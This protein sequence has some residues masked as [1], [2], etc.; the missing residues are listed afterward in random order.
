MV[1]IISKWFLKPAKVGLTQNFRQSP[2]NLGFTLIESLVAAV[3]LGILIASVAPLILISTTNRVNARRID[4]ASQAAASFVQGLRAGTIKPFAPVMFTVEGAANF[5]SILP[6]YVTNNST[7]FTYSTQL[8]KGVTAI[9]VDNDG[10]YNGF[11]D[12]II[13]AIREC[14]V[15][16][17]PILPPVKNNNCSLSAVDTN[18]LTKKDI[19]NKLNQG[20]YKLEVR[21]YRGDAFKFT[22]LNTANR[23]GVLNVTDDPLTLSA[24]VPNVSND[25]YALLRE[26]ATGFGSKYSPLTSFRTTISYSSNYIDLQEKLNP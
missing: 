23:V 26:P 22:D 12:V 1:D 17:A 9:D 3:V 19:T 6:N 2:S 8:L 14:P 20:T 25:N 18:L 10:S 11:Q 15:Y 4:Q 13:Q 24:S 16:P 5:K 21:V 7:T